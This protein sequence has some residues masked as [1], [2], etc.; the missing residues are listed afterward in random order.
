MIG[1][2]LFYGGGFIKKQ[3]LII[4]LVMLFS[5]FSPSIIEAAPI[6][7]L[8]G[9]QMSF[10]VAPTIE[11]G[12]T[13]VPMRAVFEALGAN[14]QWDSYT[15]T[16]TAQKVGT[17][18]TIILGQAVAYK[19]GS[20]VSL[21]VPAKII[22]NRTMV[23]LRFVSEALGAQVNWDGV[24]RTI[25]I[26]SSPTSGNN[27]L[28][29]P[30]YIRITTS[31]ATFSPLIELK[32]GS[33]ATVKWQVEGGD[34]Y[35]GVNPTI[36]FS[37]GGARYVRMS[38]TDG[39]LNALGDV[40]T[41]NVGFNHKQDAG[42]YN[43]GPAYNYTPQNVSNIENVNIMTNLKRFLSAT[44]TLSGALDFS[45][46]SK[47]EY[48]ECYGASVNSLK[49]TGCNSLIRLCMEKNDL[50][51]L[52]LNPFAGTLYDLRISGNRSPI[53]LAPLNSP[54]AHL[55]HYCAQSEMVI[56]H[57]TATQLP[58]IEEWWDHY[59]GQTGA[60]IVR[61]SAI[62]SLDSQGNSWTAVDLTNQFPAGRRGTAKLQNNRIS[63]IVLK[64]CK[65]LTNLNLQNN[66]LNQ[67]AVDGLLAE[68]ESW[69]TTNG[70]LI[71]SD[72]AP[73]SSIGRAKINL[74]SNRGW[75]VNYDS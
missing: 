36:D 69:G 74:L 35:I 25:T 10:E 8:D 7:L 26:L 13:L 42:K 15:Q 14:I 9:K 63:S 41:F 46:M 50:A 75:T 6:V 68:I 11:N 60:L 62:R 23:P 55:Y 54:M 65:G 2:Y 64:G 51:S 28:N 43:L 19:N 52:D 27:Y 17:V 31:G 33:L 45:G 53:T 58:V 48:I 70:T 12:T 56:N 38:V 47:L 3:A 24:T 39:G 20:R 1:Y 66:L 21:Q 37:S 29:S 32:D 18:V 49:L 34:A 40:V 44:P 72:N 73:P 57:P 16:V 5:L 30:D 71:I 59:S 22:N 4:T 61:S 67:T